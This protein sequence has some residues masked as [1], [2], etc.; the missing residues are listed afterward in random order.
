MNEPIY[1]M[2]WIFFVYKQSGVNPTET[3]PAHSSGAV[4]SHAQGQ[5]LREDRA[6]WGSC[7]H[8]YG[9]FSFDRTLIKKFTFV[10]SASYSGRFIGQ[11]FAN[12]NF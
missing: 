1:S 9:L 10:H 11:N 3:Q 7:N 6:Y 12:L 4:Q 8:T 5:L 2:L